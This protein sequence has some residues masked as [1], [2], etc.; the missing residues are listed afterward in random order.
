MQRLPNNRWICFVA[1][2]VVGCGLDLWSKHVMFAS[3][4]LRQGNVY[5]LIDGYAGFQLS[6][7]EGA[8][9]GLGQGAQ[10]WFGLLTVVAATAIP[11]WLF[12]FRAAEDFWMTTTL[13]GVVGGMLGNLYDRANLH[14]LVWGVDWPATAERHGQPIFAVRDWILLQWSND[15]RWPNFNIA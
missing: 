7:N 11:I 4:S 10:F 9:F 12:Y 13:G 14:G 6:L 1:L 15:A 5:W 2:A 8:V 3:E